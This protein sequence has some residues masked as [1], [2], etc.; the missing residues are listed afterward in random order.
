MELIKGLEIEKKRMYEVGLPSY[1]IRLE[2]ERYEVEAGVLRNGLRLCG[3]FFNEAGSIVR[4][5]RIDNRPMWKKDLNLRMGRGADFNGYP[6]YAE[7][8]NPAF[9]AEKIKAVKERYRTELYL[10]KGKKEDKKKKI[11]KE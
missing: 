9:L 3:I 1:V 11:E 5:E 2:N 10:I 8:R 4:T 7:I 6:H